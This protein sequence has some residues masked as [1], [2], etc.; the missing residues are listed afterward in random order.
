V[1]D[2]TTGMREQTRRHLC[3]AALLG[4]RHLVV[5]ANKMDLTGWDRAAYEAVDTEARALALRLGIDSVRTVPASALLGDNVVESSTLTPWYSG[6]TV[7]GALEEAPAGAWA[8]QDGGTRL[9][10]QW[11]VRHRGGG[12]SY[13]GMVNGGTLRPG[14]EVVVLP[15]GQRSRITSVETFDGP[16]DEASAALSVTV[17][18]A[19]E[20]DVSRGD[21]IASVEDPPSVEREFDAT[22]CWF[23]DAPLEAGRRFRVKHTTRLAPA[24]VLSVAGRLDVDTLELDPATA[25]G[26]NDIGVVRFVVGTP[27]VVDPY[28]RNRVTGSFVVI[29]ELTHATVAAAMV[30]APALAL[31]PSA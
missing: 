1:V 7:L 14:D 19:D 26:A 10:V 13:A 17:R 15:G 23:A 9:P 16:L 30:G 27:L 24:Q 6:P 20:L 12:R 2:A 25:L 5:V 18:L 22:V 8:G 3:I 4:V 21:L 11:V 29:D 28:R 31:S